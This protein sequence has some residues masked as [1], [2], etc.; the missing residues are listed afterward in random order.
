M[1]HGASLDARPQERNPVAAGLV[2]AA[3]AA[4]FSLVRRHRIRTGAGNPVTQLGL[5]DDR[6]VVDDAWSRPGVGRLRSRIWLVSTRD[7]RITVRGVFDGL[8]SGQRAELLA[9]A[10]AHEM[11]L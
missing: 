10:E 6:G 2:L 9:E 5:S 3:C 4:R 7:F 1:Q 8:A 11:T